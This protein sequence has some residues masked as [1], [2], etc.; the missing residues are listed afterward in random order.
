MTADD[1]MDT[2]I[3][4]G[5]DDSWQIRL[6]TVPSLVYDVIIGT[7]FLADNDVILK[8]QPFLHAFIKKTDGNTVYVRASPDSPARNL[9]G[10]SDTALA[11]TSF[12]NPKERAFRRLAE[13]A[14]TFLLYDK[15]IEKIAHPEI[16][17][18]TKKFRDRF[19]DT[20]PAC[21][22]VDRGSRNHAIELLPDKELPHLSYYG[23]NQ[24]K[25]N[26]LTKKLQDLLTAGIIVRN[27]GRTPACSPGFVVISKGK[28]RLVG[29]YRCL[30][31]AT[32]PHAQDIP[33][34]QEVLDELGKATYF[35]LSDMMSGYFQLRIVDESQEYTTFATPLGR[36]KYT[37]TAMGLRNAG[38]DF[39]KAVSACLR[40]SGLFWKATINYM[41]DIVI[42]SKTAEEHAEHIEKVLAALR[43]DG[44]YLAFDKSQIGVTR[45]KVLGHWVEHGKIFPDPTY[46]TKVTNFPSPD[47]AKNKVR[48]LQGFLGLVGYYRRFI[49]N[50]GPIAAP[51]T[52]LLK[53]ET[54]WCWTEVHEAAVNTLASSLQAT[55]DKGLTIF[56]RD[57][58]TRIY[59][60]ASGEGLGATLEQEVDGVWIPIA[61]FSKALSGAEVNLVNYERELLAIYTA[62]KK[63]L[64][65]L[66]GIHFRIR[67]DCNALRNLN[68]MSFSSR[69]RRVTTMLIFL[70]TL[71]FTWEHVKG[72]ENK[73]ADSL[74][75]V[76]SATPPKDNTLD[77]LPDDPNDP[78]ADMQRDPR[79]ED[80]EEWDFL[81]AI[82]ETDPKRPDTITKILPGNCVAYF[83]NETLREKYAKKARHRN[84]NEDLE[85][86]SLDHELKEELKDIL[87]GINTLEWDEDAPEFVSA[88]FGENADAIP[89]EVIAAETPNTVD[90]NTV[91]P[92][93]LP[94]VWKYDNDE[95]FKDE[96]EDTANGFAGHFHREITGKL[97]MYKNLIMVPLAAT[98]LVL[99]EI[100]NGFAHIALSSLRDMLSSWG[101]WWPSIKEDTQAFVESCAT[102]QLKTITS[103]R[104]FGRLGNRSRP[105]KGQEIAVDFSHLTEVG[106]FDG[107][108]GIID[109]AT[110]YVM[111]I[112]A[113]QTWTSKEYHS[114]I[115]NHWCSMFGFPTIVRSDNGSVFASEAWTKAWEAVGTSISHSTPYH[116]QANGIIERS[117]RTLKD[118]L[119][120]IYQEELHVTWPDVLAIV[121]GCHNS[122]TRESLG[123]QSPAEIMF[124]YNPR[125]NRIP[126]MTDVP[127]DTDWFKENEERFA[128]AEDLLTKAMNKYE[129]KM[130][131]ITNKKRKPW[132]PEKNDLVFISRKA[133][134]KY[135]AQLEMEYVGPVP[136]QTMTGDHRATV[137]WNGKPMDVAVSLMRP[138][139]LRQSD[140]NIRPTLVKLWE[141]MFKSDLE[142]K[143]DEGVWTPPAILDDETDEHEVTIKTSNEPDSAKDTVK[144]PSPS[145]MSPPLTPAKEKSFPFTPA[146]QK[147][148]EVA[149]KEIVDCTDSRKFP[150]R[151]EFIAR[152]HDPRTPTFKTYWFN[153]AQLSKK[154]E[155]VVT[156]AV[157]KYFR[158]QTGHTAAEIEED[159]DAGLL[160]GFLNEALFEP[161]FLEQIIRYKEKHLPA[162]VKSNKNLLAK[163]SKAIEDAP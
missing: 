126:R 3:H 16:R 27:D 150:G 136:I 99:T 137:L 133:F 7:P 34:T 87:C 19:P 148:S 4:F 79:E 25:L 73:G 156:E 30:N 54:P 42:Y 62:C 40:S 15:G 100:H 157:F 160:P 44:W 92:F 89:D 153:L 51:L 18:V 116:P 46:V 121:Q 49:P 29:D 141:A 90:E 28:A 94:E 39:Q 78:S 113:H 13:D 41:D 32:R 31:A 145:L 93:N 124:G 65:Y 80:E 120:A 112:P 76:P 57:R 110:R 128:T 130:V 138:C 11:L 60:D 36:Y 14:C 10:L 149:I 122:L 69:K 135:P 61:F 117:F 81:C 101:V 58:P 143:S 105:R 125:W 2:G 43:A 23:F 33:S 35:T 26:H 68:S 163:W 102:C 131:K 72:S 154:G 74:S 64:C 118:R 111:W 97:L 20:L 134:G 104:V 95:Y 86:G 75:R 24:E 21:R 146:S 56:A 162:W 1:Y 158:K 96:W 47:K 151:T 98:S 108:L 37:V 83:P 144:T 127:K 53:K 103:G 12:E 115:I 114:A 106:A 88:L 91:I 129:E 17:E 82:S 132:I 45:I 38:S 67:C 77:I 84:V 9:T 140:E 6:L 109:R 50:F 147:M 123:G 107:V 119:K 59:T 22:P 155:W 48:A 70:G 161:R 55:V 8:F 142:T 85:L 63:W 152:G 159:C 139:R 71:S 5:T 52:A 66:Q